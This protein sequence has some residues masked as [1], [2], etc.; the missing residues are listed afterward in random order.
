MRE[1][2]WLNV[3]ALATWLIC[4]LPY[5][6]AIV[7][8][9]FGDWPAMLW[10]VAFAVFGATLLVLLGL[11]GTRLSR[12]RY[13]ALVFIAVEIAAALTVITLSLEHR[14]GANSTPAL[15]VIVAAIL[16]Y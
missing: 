12:A 2:R 14:Y 15:L 3:A 9:A 10:L 16:P 13:S 5:F 4:G 1:W 8:G 6:V 11:V 7:Q